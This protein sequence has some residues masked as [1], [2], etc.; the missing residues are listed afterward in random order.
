M[1]TL[2]VMPL[3]TMLPLDSIPCPQMLIIGTHSIL[4]PEPLTLSQSRCQMSLW[5]ALKSPL[6]V[7]ADLT[8]VNVPPA[9]IDVLK[10]PEVLAVADDPLGRE[11]LRLEDQPGS[12]SEGEIYA[13]PLHG[14][15]HVV[16]FFNRNS[17]GAVNMSF[18]LGDVMAS[19]DSTWAVRD[20]WS[21]T[22]NGT[23]AGSGHLDVTVPPQDVV[24]VRLSNTT[25]S[26]P[27]DNTN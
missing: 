12:T 27:S 11:A 9:V 14:G 10:N 1:V 8:N 26:S 5:T 23:V 2:S 24:M 19:A 15:D 21:H 22:D 20:L 17:N 25:G 16:V 3:T 7:S 18:H 13:G 6:L 4:F